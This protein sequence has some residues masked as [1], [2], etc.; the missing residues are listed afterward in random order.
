MVEGRERRKKQRIQLTRALIGRFGVMGVVILDITDAGARIEH[1]DRL[2]LR[3]KAS[4]RLD[5]QQQTIE[6][7]AEVRSC[8]IHRFASGDQGATVY[9]SGLLFTDYVGEAQAKLRE[10]TTF[11]V[12]RSLAEQVANARGLGPVTERNMPV[13]RSGAVA[14]SGLEPGQDAKRLIPDTDLAVERGYV[15]CTLVGGNRFEKRWS[16]TPDQP[17][18]GFTIPA[19]EPEEHVNQLCESYLQGSEE[20]RKLILLLARLSVDKS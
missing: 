14:A 1:F 7:T 15:R 9:Q 4:F 10:L 11:V 2:D 19:S 3:K 20:D 18:H 13:F 8:R 5:W 16:R 17:D 12:A 6:T